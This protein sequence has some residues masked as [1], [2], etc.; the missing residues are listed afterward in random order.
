LVILAV[1]LRA[2][3]VYVAYLSHPVEVEKCDV[4]SGPLSGITF[5]ELR[6]HLATQLEQPILSFD[7]LGSSILPA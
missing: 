7:I 3:A 4:L 5:P 1:C 6:V 2:R